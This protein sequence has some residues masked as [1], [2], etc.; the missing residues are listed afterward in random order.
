MNTDSSIDDELF[1]NLT[2]SL[3]VC[4]KDKVSTI[5]VEAVFALFRLQDPANKE[6]PVTKR[7]SNQNLS[8]IH[9][10]E[11]VFWVYLVICVNRA[12]EFLKISSDYI[13]LPKL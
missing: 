3:L 8:V 12:H 13:S 5:R 11:N 7:K 10:T 1:E 6:C 4:L 9:F 2:E